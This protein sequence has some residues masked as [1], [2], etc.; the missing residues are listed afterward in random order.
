MD[1]RTELETKGYC[2][3]PNVLNEEECLQAYNM[4]NEWKDS[5]PNH[6]KFHC[7]VDPHGIYKYL[8]VGHTRHAWFIRTRQNVQNVFIVDVEN[9]ETQHMVKNNLAKLSNRFKPKTRKMRKSAN[10]T[11]RRTRSATPST[12]RK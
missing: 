8:E 6:D 9:I 7:N 10:K 11:M 3:I 2:V 12:R 5:I 1:I 4:F